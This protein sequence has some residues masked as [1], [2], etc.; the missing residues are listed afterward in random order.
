MHQLATVVVS[1]TGIGEE[2]RR[3]R[4]ASNMLTTKITFIGWLLEVSLNSPSY[5]I[6][7]TDLTDIS[8]E[9]S[10]SCGEISDFYA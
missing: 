9:K 5:L 10:L 2:E 7:V 8:V 3:H 1:L 4:R 6:F